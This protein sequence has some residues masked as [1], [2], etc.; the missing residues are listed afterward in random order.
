MR[1]TIEEDKMRQEREIA[2]KKQRMIWRII[3][4]VIL[5]AM[6]TLVSFGRYIGSVARYINDLAIDFFMRYF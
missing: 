3:L 2:E 5:L 6:V 4:A 1:M